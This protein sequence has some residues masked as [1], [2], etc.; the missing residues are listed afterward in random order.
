MSQRSMVKR[1]R[2]GFT[3]LEVLM[4]VVILGL[5]AAALVTTLKGTEDKAKNDVTKLLIEKV[6]SSLE[7]YNMHMGHYPTESEGGLRALLEKPDT[8]EAAKKWGGPYL[9]ATDLK[10]VWET[11]LSYEAPGRVNSESFDLSSAGKNRELGDDD[12]I[13]NWVTK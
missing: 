3:L 12:D 5:L 9:K 4:V 6:S 7:R 11:D 1:S 13:T 2:R 8:D 10:D